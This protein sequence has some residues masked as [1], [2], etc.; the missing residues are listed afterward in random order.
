VDTPDALVQYAAEQTSMA[1]D[2]AAT[3]SAA[4]GAAQSPVPAMTCIG[5]DETLLGEITVLG[6]PAYAVRDTATGELR[7]V[8]QADCRVLFGVTP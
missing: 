2:S 1:A 8:A 5:G 4:G 3:D 6:E 7:A